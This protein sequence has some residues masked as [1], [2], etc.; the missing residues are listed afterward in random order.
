MKARSVFSCFIFFP[1]F[2]ATCVTAPAQ[3]AKH[4]PSSR[5]QTADSEARNQLETYLA[6][7]QGDPK[8][9]SLRSKIIELAKS[10]TPA[11]AISQLAQD[12][13]ARA[14]SQMSAASSADDFETVGQLF[15]QVAIL[16]PWF[17][18][19]YY[20][21][22]SAYTKANEYDSA[23]RNLALY[24][25]AARPG[26]DTRNPEVLRREL[27]RKQALQFQQ[28]VQ[29][30]TANPTD[31]TRMHL[32]QMAQAMG[33]QPE[34]PE[35][36]RGHYV[37]AVVYGNSASD[38][39][40]Y[41]RAITEYKAALLVAPWWGDAYKKLAGAQ[42]LAGHYDEAITNLIFYQAVQPSEARATQDEIYRLKAL[43]RRAADEDAKKQTEEQRLKLAQEQQQKERALIDSMKFTI[44]GSWYLVTAPTG[45]FVGGESNPQC[46][47]IVKH[48][49]GRWEI[50]NKCAPSKR[51]I[52]DIDVPPRQL[53]F[54]LTGRDAAFP[55][56][57]VMVTLSLSSDGQTLDGRAVTYDKKFAIFGDNPVR[58]MRR[59]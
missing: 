45:Y 36:A 19:A 7:F 49:A 30:F 38:S 4:T 10:L 8:D 32:I 25:A 37:M 18:D 14:V 26:V 21:A 50:K 2:C 43:G 48:N 9:A 22:A 15:E 29:Q 40:D 28:I 34:I 59:K 23:R 33:T 52:D 44:E 11:P 39:T 54:K 13:F 1:L 55:F 6:E 24:Q 27:D 47:Y 58:W 31:A 56:S 5:Q 16:A 51:S 17:S 3:T 46:D 35:E 20:N 57:E 53:S 42:T 41:E 12:D